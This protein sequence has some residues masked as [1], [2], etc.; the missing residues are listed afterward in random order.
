MY[1]KDVAID[2]VTGA[3]TGGTTLPAETYSYLADA[4]DHSFTGE[5]TWGGGCSDSFGTGDFNGD[6]L[7]DVYCH[8]EWGTGKLDI[9][10]SNGSGF[11]FPDW[12]SHCGANEDWL[13]TGDF[14]G[15]GKTDFLCKHNQGAAEVRLSGDPTPSWDDWTPI[16]CKTADGVMTS[17]DWNGDG[18]TDVACHTTGSDTPSIE[19]KLSTGSAFVVSGGWLTNWCRPQGGTS[20]G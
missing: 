4:S 1:G 14:D 5:G 10:L 9:G 8:K 7:Q 15:D 12:G 2:P 16:W 17:G 18:K 19:V 20:W 13:S 6:G 3:I 11:T